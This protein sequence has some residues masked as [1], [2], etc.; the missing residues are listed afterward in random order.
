MEIVLRE[1]QL[2]MVARLYPTT[3]QK[4]LN[5]IAQKTVVKNNVFH[6]LSG[7]LA[8]PKK[9]HIPSKVRV[10]P[11]FTYPSLKTNQNPLLG[12]DSFLG[13]A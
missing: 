4:Y 1:Y 8:Y 3:G 9:Q 12:I 7:R 10:L 13:F 11:D 6:L 2:N 5:Y